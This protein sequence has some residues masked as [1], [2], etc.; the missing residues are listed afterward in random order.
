MNSRVYIFVEC[1]KYTRAET[2]F[3][4]FKRERFFAYQDRIFQLS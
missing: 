4:V 1:E 2:A 3:A